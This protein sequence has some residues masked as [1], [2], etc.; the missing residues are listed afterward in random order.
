MAT[1]PKPG[2]ANSTYRPPSASTI[3]RKTTSSAT[4]RPGV[5]IQDPGA[6]YDVVAPTNTKG[7]TTAR[8]ISPGS[9]APAAQT[10]K[11][12]AARSVGASPVISAAAQ[13]TGTAPVSATGTRYND[14]AQGGFGLPGDPWTGFSQRYAPA[15]ADILLSNPSQIFYDQANAMGLQQPGGEMGATQ[16]LAPYADL[17][18][19]LYSLFN[20]GR[21]NA[22][23]PEAQTNFIAQFAKNMLTPGGS[24]PSIQGIMSSVYGNPDIAELY[25]TGNPAENVNTLND[26]IGMAAGLSFN[27]VMQRMVQARNDRLAYEYLSDYTQGGNP[28]SYADFVR[29]RGGAGSFYG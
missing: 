9:A 24:A 15:Y 20:S 4:I 16:A 29:S 6:G 28:G 18:P 17:M 25:N 23:S 11:M 2:F 8:V 12:A 7:T 1:K 19:F 22:G 14:A 26:M 13:N 3:A 10:A 5:G 21:A 27:P